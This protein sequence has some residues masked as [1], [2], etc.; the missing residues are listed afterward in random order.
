[1]KYLI[2]DGGMVPLPDGM[3]YA[4]GVAYSVQR[5]R[6]ITLAMKHA[7]FANTGTSAPTTRE[8]AALL[9]LL[10]RIAVSLEVDDA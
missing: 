4:D 8:S 5:K 10:A 7:N 9:A 2:T 3:S 6:L 1:M